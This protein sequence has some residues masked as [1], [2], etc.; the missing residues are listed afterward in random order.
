[1]ANTEFELTTMRSRVR[2][3]TSGASQVLLSASFYFVL[4]NFPQHHH[5]LPISYSY[6]RFAI[7]VLQKLK[8]KMPCGAGL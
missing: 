2:C 3:S 8:Q 5:N 1:M 4:P 7:G 6:R